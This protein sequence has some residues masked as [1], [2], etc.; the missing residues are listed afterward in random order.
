M[1]LFPIMPPTLV[2]VETTTECSVGGFGTIQ[3]TNRTAWDRSWSI[4]NGTIVTKIGWNTANPESGAQF[5]IS[6]RINGTTYRTKATVAGNHTGGGLEYFTLATP[7]KVPGSGTFHV[8]VFSGSDLHT[9][10]QGS[11][12]DANVTGKASTTIDA[13]VTVVE[14][15]GGAM[16]Q[17]VQYAEF[18]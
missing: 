6:E 16:Y 1:S 5:Y 10:E 18:Q 2:L 9:G 14:S 15:T 12:T 3:F 13:D 4:D 11:T 7:Y 17:C 8:G